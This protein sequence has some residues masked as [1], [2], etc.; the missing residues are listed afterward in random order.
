MAGA[1]VA[2]AG[3]MYSSGACVAGAA[4]QAASTSVATTTNSMNRP[5][6]DF[7]LS[8]VVKMIFIWR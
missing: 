2:A 6:P 4:P 1:S 3:S 5:D 8:S 7:I